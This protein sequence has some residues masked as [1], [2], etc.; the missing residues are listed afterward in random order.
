MRCLTRRRGAAHFGAGTAGLRRESRREGAPDG[1]LYRCFGGRSGRFPGA[2]TTSA[3]SS[4]TRASRRASRTRISWSTPAR[5]HFILT[6][7]EKRVAPEDL[8]F[9]LALMEHLAARGLTCPQPVK[10]RTGDAARLRR[11]PAGRD[12]DLPRRHVDPPPERRRIAR[13]S[14]RRWR[15]LHLAGRGFCRCERRNALSVDGWRP[16][17]VACGGAAPTACSRACARRSSAS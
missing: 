7:Y 4:P 12:R 5:G 8:P 1:R 2:T 16:L 3:S 10:N 14:A 9:F 13:R 11:G 15:R 17:Y 6:L